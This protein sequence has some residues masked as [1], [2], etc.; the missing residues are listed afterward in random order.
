MAKKKKKTGSGCQL[1]VPTRHTILAIF[2]ASLLDNEVSL[3]SVTAAVCMEINAI[4]RHTLAK[5]E[6]SGVG[7]LPAAVDE[8]VSKNRDKVKHITPYIV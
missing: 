4:K 6:K 5:I 8:A 7:S 3:S 1:I 2:P